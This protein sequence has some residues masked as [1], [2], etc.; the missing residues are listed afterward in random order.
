M[1]R[2]CVHKQSS[3]L[4]VRGEAIGIALVLLCVALPTLE[5][6]L[7]EVTGSAG[8]RAA[9]GTVPGSVAA[10]V[11]DK[12]APR[13][14]AKELAWATFTCLRN[15]NTCTMLVVK[16]GSVAAARG[17]LGVACAAGQNGGKPDWRAVE[18]M[19]SRDLEGTSSIAQQLPQEGLHLKTR[20]EITGSAV[21]SWQSIPEGCQAAFVMPLASGDEDE[22]ASFVV[23]LSEAEDGF[24][25]KDL[26]WLR[27]IRSKLEGVFT[28]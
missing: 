18:S 9:E 14:V 21:G 12:K 23:A 17:A 5:R 15:T 16:D 6:Q 28:K 11:F 1:Q 3:H 26:A 22:G 8:R 4:Q 27:S 24:G 2:T 7:A 13:P 19:V 20:R 25:G 10:F